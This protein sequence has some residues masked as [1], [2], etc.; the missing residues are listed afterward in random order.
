[1]GLE[2]PDR[3]STPLVTALDADDEL[4]GFQVATDVG[5]PV[6]FA[7]PAL[8]PGLAVA[9]GANATLGTGLGTNAS[10]ITAL[11]TNATLQGLYEPR[12]QSKPTASLGQTLPRNTPLANIA[13]SL[14]TA[15]ATYVGIYV[16][17]GQTVT[18]ITFYSATT[19]LGTGTNQF[20]SL[21]NAAFG[22]LAVTNDDTSTAWAANS[23]KTL[24]LASPYVVPTSGW[25]YFGCNVV[26]TTVPTLAGISTLAA[27]N[28]LAPRVSFVDSTSVISN[29]ASAPAT[30]IPADTTVIPYAT[31]A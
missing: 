14:T 23:A 15:R 2:S 22:K 20:F 25:Y 8:V 13:S 10:L 29:P 16:Q 4:L 17:A 11:G 27:I 3:K 26:A 28:A 5:L 21:Y 24:T 30:A 6:R 9:A 18:T 31:F 1:M 7:V 19:A 12:N